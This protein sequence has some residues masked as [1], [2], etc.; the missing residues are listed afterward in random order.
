MKSR[1]ILLAIIAIAIVL[2]FVLNGHQ[3][4]TLA[5]MQVQQLKLQQ[6]YSEHPLWFIG[7]YFAA[8]VIVAALSLPGA[9]IMTLLGG[10]LFGLIT[11]AVVIS[12]ASSLGATLAFWSSRYILRDSI[13]R[14]FAKQLGKIQQGV[15]AD[16]AFY[17]FSMRLVPLFP[18]WIVNLLFGLTRLPTWQFYLVSQIAMLPATL[19]YVNAGTQL[20]QLE[21]LSDILSPSLIAS[22]ALLGLFP[23]LARWLLRL[24]RKAPEIKP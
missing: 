20:A 16:G 6:A 17:L 7:G 4:L 18:F 22:F 15:A 11:G 9:S 13:E 24:V 12:F 19:V 14:K 10:A 3:Q 8:Y 1:L 21:Q 5:N 2:F 23:L